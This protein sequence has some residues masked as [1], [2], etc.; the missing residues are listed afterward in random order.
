VWTTSGGD[1]S[2]WTISANT[3]LT[4]FAAAPR[5]H[6]AQLARHGQH[7]G[8]KA[9]AHAAPAGIRD[10]WDGRAGPCWLERGQLVELR[11]L[12]HRLDT[13]IA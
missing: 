4:G 5:R 8:D 3:G 6:L 10:T 9:A 13:R 11:R 7:P 12:H 1:F 2:S